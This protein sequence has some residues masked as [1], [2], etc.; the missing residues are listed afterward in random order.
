[1][2][3]A[4]NAAGLARLSIVKKALESI[5]LKSTIKGLFD[6]RGFVQNHSTPMVCFKMG[7]TTR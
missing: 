3:T 2:S 6:F 5:T 1:M 4:K 7:I